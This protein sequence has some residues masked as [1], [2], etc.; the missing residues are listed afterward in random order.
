SVGLTEYENNYFGFLIGAD[1]T[2]TSFSNDGWGNI[3]ESVSD[4]IYAI[5]YA[6]AKVVRSDSQ[7]ITTNVDTS[8]AVSNITT[9]T[10]YDQYG[11][12]LS[13]EGHGETSSTAVG[14]QYVDQYLV[15]DGTITWLSHTD[16][17]VSQR[18]TVI[19]GQLKILKNE[20]TSTTEARDGSLT[21]SHVETTHSYDNGVIAGSG[22]STGITTT[23]G[24]GSVTFSYMDITYSYVNGEFVSGYGSGMTEGTTMGWTVTDTVTGDMT[25]TVISEYA[26][27]I[28]QYFEGFRGQAKLMESRSDTTTTILDSGVGE[29]KSWSHSVMD[30]FYEYT[31]GEVRDVTIGYDVGG[32]LSISISTW[33]RLDGA[34]GSGWTHSESIGYEYYDEEMAGLG[35]TGTL[36]YT[37]SSDATITQTYTIVYGQAKVE[38]SDSVSTSY[39]ADGSESYSDVTTEYIYD[40]ANG[41]LLGATGSGITGSIGVEVTVTLSDGSTGTV[42]SSRSAGSML[43]TYEVW[44]G[45]AKNILTYSD[46]VGTNID[47]TKYHATSTTYNGYDTDYGLLVT[48]TGESINVSSDLYDNKTT[49]W[50][51]NNSWIY[52]GSAKQIQTTSTSNTANLDGSYAN[53]YMSTTYWY[54]EYGH[55]IYGIGIGTNESNAVGLADSREGDVVSTVVSSDT[56]GEVYQR[57]GVYY[58]QFKVLDT[59]TTSH[60]VNADGS[61]S[62]QEMTTTYYYD[63]YGELQSAH[64][65]G[66]SWSTSVGYVYIDEDGNTDGTI[67]VVSET[68]A[69]IEQTY[70]VIGGMAKVE[71]VQNWSHTLSG[72]FETS[73][74]LGTLG[75]LSTTGITS[76]SFGYMET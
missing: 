67:T 73:G 32:T 18:F 52:L 2:S 41:L 49:T 60:T 21:Y 10:Y 75:D 62:I 70:T 72:E 43:Q 54:D 56:T 74:T 9:T 53:S 6:Q 35:T 42:R 19:D 17:T 31:D 22:S 26:T 38:E 57:Y 37:G 16:G 63:E 65:M 55:G 13:G 12:V 30:T 29:I 3:T 11:F 39:S 28:E 36:V 40:S 59:V 58:G 69:T 44:Y 46:V 50:S 15:T 34:S 64:G 4:Q 68:V 14:Y 33:G 51:V 45:A 8:T 71:L 1:G 25:L 5:Y 23:A 76:E 61:E 20:T 48:S 47:G 24:D 66:N 7:S 27:E